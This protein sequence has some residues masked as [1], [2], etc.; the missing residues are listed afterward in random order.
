MRKQE[1]KK[2]KICI[3][4]KAWEKLFRLYKT[5]SLQFTNYT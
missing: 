4:I 3:G 5:T 2:E 1:K